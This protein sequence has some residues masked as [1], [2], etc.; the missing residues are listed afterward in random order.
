[1]LPIPSDSERFASIYLD[2]AA[3]TY[4]KPERVYEAV[5][6]FMRE[7]GGS[8]GRSAHSRAVETSRTVYSVRESVAS[9]VGARDPL[10]MVFT[11]NATEAINIALRGLLSPG[12]H[13][14]IT[15]M[16]HNSLMRPLQEMSLQG[17]EYSVALCRRDGTLDPA[18]MAEQVRSNT[19][20][21]AMTHASNV[22]GSIMP[23]A[24]AARIA[25]KH[26]LLLLLDAAQTAGRL[27]LAGD[28][29]L[30]DAIAFSGHKELFGPQGTG[31]LYIRKGLAIKPM[32]CGGTGSES[33][34]I[35]QPTELPEALESGTLNAPGIAGL[36]AGVSFVR[37]VGIDEIRRHEIELMGRMLDGLAGIKGVVS[38]GPDIK[39]RIGIAA[40]TFEGHTPPEIAEKLD[41]RY[42]IATR[43][44]LHCSPMAH[45]TMGTAQTG[46]LRVSLSYMN[47]AEDV[48]HLLTALRELLK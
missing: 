35:T 23:L 36:G 10:R 42:G 41:S 4:P 32:I 21:I 22:T 11:K 2:N 31:C 14:I 38:H 19:K 37:D 24:D 16:E 47:S 8:A 48:D 43:A 20:M 46:A 9:I 40:L 5:E 18:A 12:D 13:V 15:S 3:T 26:G 33:A 7:I 25:G 39:K 6:R 45:R 44:G 28:A 30:A 17:V 27:P 1:M 29:D 34:S